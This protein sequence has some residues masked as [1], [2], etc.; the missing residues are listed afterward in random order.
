MAFILDQ[1]AKKN[2]GIFVDFFGK[3]ACTSHGLAQ[4]AALSGH[5]IFP[6]TCR[7]ERD[8]RNL[9]VEIGEEIPGPTDRSEEEV[10]RVTQ[11]CTRYL[12]RFIREHPE[13]WIW[14]HRRWKTK[15]D[16]EIPG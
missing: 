4:M 10:H 8:T 15:P 13:Q 5:K 3:P 2:W 7:R 11:E 12:E 9:I 1:N 6:V 14:M 16:P